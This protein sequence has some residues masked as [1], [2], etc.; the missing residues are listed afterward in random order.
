[1]EERK[2]TYNGQELLNDF[3]EPRAHYEGD[4]IVFSWKEGESTSVIIDQL[5]SLAAS[6]KMPGGVQQFTMQV[7]RMNKYGRMPEDGCFIFDA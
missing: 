5:R 2:V 6:G 3:G 4:K 7:V 1:M